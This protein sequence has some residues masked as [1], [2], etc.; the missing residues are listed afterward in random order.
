MYIFNI[1]WNTPWYSYMIRYD[2]FLPCWAIWNHLESPASSNLLQETFSPGVDG[3]QRFALLRKPRLSRGTVASDATG[4]EDAGGTERCCRTTGGRCPEESVL[5]GMAWSIV[6]A[7]LMVYR[8]LSKDERF[9]S[10]D[11]KESYSLLN[12][13]GQHLYKHNYLQSLDHFVSMTFGFQKSTWEN[14]IVLE[15]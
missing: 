3:L 7:L 8:S 5:K 12:C 14:L 1:V 2:V 10:T 9:N 6:E 13:N 11:S 4:S 15:A